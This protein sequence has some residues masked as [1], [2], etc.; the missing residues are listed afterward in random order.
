MSDNP[1]SKP[2]AW[3]DTPQPVRQL[4][5]FKAVAI[6]GGVAALALATAR[7]AN[8]DVG[9]GHQDKGGGTGADGGRGRRGR[10][11]RWVRRG[12]RRRW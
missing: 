5:I 7:E 9:W 4:F 6:L 8:A 2:D 12:R 10:S 1:D 3:P 11:G